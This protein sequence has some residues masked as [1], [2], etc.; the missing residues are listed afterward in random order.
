MDA[1]ESML[2]VLA[3]N[4]FTFDVERHQAFRQYYSL[5]LDNINLK[6]WYQLIFH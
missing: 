6:L 1:L 2:D 4:K 3:N 5:L